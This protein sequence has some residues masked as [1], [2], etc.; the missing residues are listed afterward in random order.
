[1]LR[2]VLL[3]VSTAMINNTAALDEFFVP[4]ACST[5]KERPQAGGFDADLFKA[6]L[7]SVKE[8]EAHLCRINYRFV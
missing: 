6:L 3:V 8:V 7:C 4:M 2:S 1:V 5:S